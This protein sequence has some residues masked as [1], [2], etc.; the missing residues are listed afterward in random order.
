MAVASFACGIF[1]PCKAVKI[2]GA[3]AAGTFLSGYSLSALKDSAK[4]AVDALD[5]RIQQLNSG[6]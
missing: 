6:C 1:G 3:V 2:S 4:A 5:A